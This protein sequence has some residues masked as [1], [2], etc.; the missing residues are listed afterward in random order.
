MKIPPLV[1][2]VLEDQSNYMFLTLI[3]YKKVK[4]LTIIENIVGDE[5][6]AYALDSLAAEGI[7]QDWFMSVATRWFY[8]ASDR[9]PLSFEL[10]KLGRHDVVQ[11]LL[12]TFSTSSVSRLIGRVFSYRIDEPPKVRRRRVKPVQQVTEIK[13]KAIKN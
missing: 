8:S 12:K 3:E 9:Y 10:T 13:L 11:K 7:D 5:I 1:A 6:K 4:H 2:E